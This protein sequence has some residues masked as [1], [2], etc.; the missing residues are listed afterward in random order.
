MYSVWFKDLTPTEK[1]QFKELF[2]NSPRLLGQL[3]KV[4]QNE[5]DSAVR[6]E[7]S[8]QDF[9][10]PSWS[11]KQA[12]RNGYVSAFRHVIDLITIKDQTK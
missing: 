10:T 12:W 3:T 4:L 8:I 1:E 6:Q 2:K 7:S 9:D 11:H 5:L